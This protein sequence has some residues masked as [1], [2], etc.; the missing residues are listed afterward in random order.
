MN[1][2]TTVTVHYTKLNGTRAEVTY[3]TRAYAEQKVA[4]SKAA[5]LG[6]DMA[7]EY[8]T[9]G[10]PLTFAQPV[11]ESVPTTSFEDR[12][13]AMSAAEKADFMASAAEE[14]DCVE[15]EERTGATKSLP[16]GWSQR[17]GQVRN[18]FGRRVA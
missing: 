2:S 6:H 7:E 15:A 13:A 12:W 5:H 17:R 1:N 8:R 3:S 4:N 14:N 18:Q 11:A 10:K 9:E 16:R